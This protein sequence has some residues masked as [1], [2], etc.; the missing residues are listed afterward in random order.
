MSTE[1]DDL[2]RLCEQH[3][4]V[5]EAC[6]LRANDAEATCRAILAANGEAVRVLLTTVRAL[7]DSVNALYD[8]AWSRLDAQGRDALTKGLVDKAGLQALEG[9][10]RRAGAMAHIRAQLPQEAELLSTMETRWAENKKLEERLQ[11]TQALYNETMQRLKD[12]QRLLKETT[13]RLPGT[14]EP[15]VP[16]PPKKAAEPGPVEPEVPQSSTPPKKVR[17]P[18]DPNA[19]KKVRKPVDPNAPKKARAPKDSNA[20]PKKRRTEVAAKLPS[21]LES[22]TQAWDWEDC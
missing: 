1:I 19:P 13:S 4:L 20:P 6:V 14:A 15:E 3:G 16:T 21:R 17:K 5:A 12:A 11:A 7:P 22:R 9:E 2:V 8:L 18:A 10:N